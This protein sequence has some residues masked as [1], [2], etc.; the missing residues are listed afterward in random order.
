MHTGPTL[1]ARLPAGGWQVGCWVDADGRTLVDVADPWGALA[2]R[3]AGARRAVPSI[4]AGW[5]GSA[6]DPQGYAQRW[7]LAIGHAPAGH[8]HVVSFI[9]SADEACLGQLTLPPE[10]LSGFWMS[11]SGVWVAAAVGSYTHVRLIAQ[12]ATLLHPLHQVAGVPSGPGHVMT[13]RGGCR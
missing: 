2:Y 10:A 3:M 6:P 13:A 7:A 5:A 1:W 9:Q 12:A 4:D 8:G 11:D